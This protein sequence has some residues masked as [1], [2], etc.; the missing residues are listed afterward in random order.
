MK[1]YP[2]DEV[3]DDAKQ[4]M[5]DGAII[6]QQWLCQYCGQKQTMD[7][8]DTFYTHGICEECGKETNIKVCGHNFMA[9]FKRKGT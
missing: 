2:W 1:I 3:I 9:V 6:F 7:I 4:K 8:E 5:A